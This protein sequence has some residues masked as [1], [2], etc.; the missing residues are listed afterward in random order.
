M[1]FRQRKAS[2]F[3]NDQLAGML[4]ACERDIRK[5]TGL[6]WWQGMCQHVIMQAAQYCSHVRL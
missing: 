2:S 6:C 5:Q 1:L 4:P 3:G